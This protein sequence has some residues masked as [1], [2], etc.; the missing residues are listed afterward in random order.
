MDPFEVYRIYMSLKLHFTT[1]DYDI[2]KVKS[3]VR[4]KPETFAKRKDI[5]LFRKLAKKYAFPDLVNYFVSNFVAGH[6]GLFDAE[7]D[8]IYLNWKARQERLGYLF[9]QDIDLLLREAEKENKDPLISNDG[10]HPVFFKLYLGNKI[11]IETVIILDKLFD[12]V[13]NNSSLSQDFL[14]KDFALLVTKYRKFIRI[15]RDK[16]RKLWIKGKG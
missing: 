10:Q 13:Y 14:W 16:Y 4:C 7:S 11:S 1:P 9:S 8:E 6:N 3:A 12:V 2:T 15:D 5:L